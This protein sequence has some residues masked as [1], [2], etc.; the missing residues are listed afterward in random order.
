MLFIKLNYNILMKKDHIF[1]CTLCFGII[2]IISIGM[3]SG[4]VIGSYSEMIYT[5]SN[6]Q[7]TYN[8]TTGCQ[9]NSSTCDNFIKCHDPFYVNCGLGIYLGI[10]CAIPIIIFFICIFLAICRRYYLL[11]N[12]NNNTE[13]ISKE[14]NIDTNNDL[15]ME[16]NSI[17]DNVKPN[18]ET[19]NDISNF[20]AV[21]LS[22]N[23][24]DKD[25]ITIVA[26][27]SDITKPCG[28]ATTSNS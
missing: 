5:K 6:Y 12:T 17:D 2:L 28:T 4:Y 8:M 9:L 7:F 18:I 25:N 3:T 20:S 1:R 27:S 11:K 24:N 14:N 26:P 13:V 21:D 15:I 16:L 22:S 19:S 23:S 10:M